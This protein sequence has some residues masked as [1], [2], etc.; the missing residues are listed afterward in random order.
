[1]NTSN[2]ALMKSHVSPASPAVKARKS[3]VSNDRFY[4]PE[5]TVSQLIGLVDMD[6]YE[7]IIE[8]S[9]GDGAILHRLPNRAVG[10]DLEPH[11]S[12]IQPMNWLE[13]TDA[14]G[15]HDDAMYIAD[16]AFHWSFGK[17]LVIGN[18]PFGRQGSLASRFFNEAAS[19]ADTIALIMPKSYMKDSMMNRLEHHFHI[20]TIVPVVDDHYLIPGGTR[21]VPTVIIVAHRERSA[22]KDHIIV[23]HVDMSSLPFVFTNHDDA[24]Y[25]V[26]RVGGKSGSLASMDAVTDTN[27]KYNYFIKITDDSVDIHELFSKAQQRLHVMRDMTTGPRSISKN[28][29]V[30]AIMSV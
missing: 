17:T 28:E 16:K 29:L 26:I 27:R 7:N 4:T 9:A 21:V 13:P 15:N 8:P 5:S 18:P 11:S 22:R 10:Y 23:N 6:D 14:E 12:D 24:D 30:D 2:A 25:M 3:G 19:F 20:D 1:M